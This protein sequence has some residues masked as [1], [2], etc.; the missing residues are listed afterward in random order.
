LIDVNVQV[1]PGEIVGVAGVAGSGQRELCEVAL[2]LRPVVAGEVRVGAPVAV[3]VDGGGRAAV[4]AA[5]RAGVVGVPEDPVAEAVVADLSVLAHMVLDGRP[6]PRRGGDIDWKAVA[7]RTD[8][9]DSAIGLHLV[10]RR[11]R[12][13]ELSGG[14]IQRVMLTRAFGQ[15]SALVVAAYPSR[16][17]DIANTRRTQELL[18]G[19]AA[20]GAG[21]LVVSE[22]LDELLSLCDRLIVMYCGRVTGTVAAAGADRRSVGR[23]MLGAAS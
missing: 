11:R 18:L 16:G 5:I 13:A 21:V 15:D 1:H 19:R 3:R 20:A 12:L 22:D 4:R 2:G 17:L 14:N 10:D 6:A 9:A 7:R 8:A 23:L